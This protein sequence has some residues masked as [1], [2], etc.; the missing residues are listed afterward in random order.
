MRLMYIVHI[1]AGSLGLIF[2]YVALFTAKGNTVHRKSGRLFIYVM[3]TMCTMGALMAA[4]SGVWTVIN[5]PAAWTTA[6][7]VMTGMATVRRPAGW[8]RRLD[9]GLMVIALSVAL[10]MLAMGVQAVAAGG[11]RNGIPA[12]PFFLFGIVGLLGGLGDARV[13]RTGALIGATRLARHLWRM[14]FALFIAAMSFF[15]GQSGVFPAAIRKPA[16]LAIPVVAVLFSMIYW[17]WR[18]RIRRSLRGMAIGRPASSATQ[19][20]LHPQN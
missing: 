8:S 17:L 20:A 9:V 19:A 16:L 5:V 3:L 14:S 15:F 10:A 6:Y 18:V 11:E 1:L 13:V 12:F 4:L 2:G 7:L